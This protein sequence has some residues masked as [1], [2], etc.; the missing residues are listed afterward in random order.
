MKTLKISYNNILPINLR[1]DSF[2]NNPI[3][4]S[5]LKYCSSH[6]TSWSKWRNLKQFINKVT[7]LKCDM[8]FS[9][10]VTY[11]PK[12]GNKIIGFIKIQIQSD[13]G[14]NKR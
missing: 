3:H 2:R 4:L 7:T 13:L 12:H 5:C 6:A 14:S 1:Y 8:D 9:Q 11:S 10:I